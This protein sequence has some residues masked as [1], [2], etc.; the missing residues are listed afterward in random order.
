MYRLE[1]P[2]YLYFLA[3]VV[4]LTV[5]FLFQIFWKRKKQREFADDDL[6][7]QL[8]PNT[9]FFKSIVKFSI[10]ALALI[11]LIIALINPKIGTKME[12]VKRQ[13]IDIV[14]A[15]DVSKVC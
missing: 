4:V 15:V 5:L 12:T 2:K 1:E 7:K 14:F 11:A 8:A 9:S 10:L 3:V 13:G 6:L